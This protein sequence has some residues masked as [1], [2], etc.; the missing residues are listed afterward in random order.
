M[1]RCVAV[2]IPRRQAT[3]SCGSRPVP[4]P[5]ACDISSE[6]EAGL[7][8]VLNFL[9]E[10]FGFMKARRKFWL[11]PVFMVMALLGA[12]IVF[13]KGSVVAPFIYTLF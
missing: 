13:S 4:R 5:T 3:G 12:L 1:I 7:L 11:A 10:F 9:V 6:P 2:A 8:F